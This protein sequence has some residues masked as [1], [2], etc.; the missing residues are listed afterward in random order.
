MLAV[1]IELDRTVT[2]EVCDAVYEIASLPRKKK[3]RKN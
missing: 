3:P 1:Q 2:K